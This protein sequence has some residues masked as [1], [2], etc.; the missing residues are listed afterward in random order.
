MSLVLS[1]GTRMRS[2]LVIIYNCD[3]ETDCANK[4]FDVTM[5]ATSL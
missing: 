3:A 1:S 2:I 4:V 5:E